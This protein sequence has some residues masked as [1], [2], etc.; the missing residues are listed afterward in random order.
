MTVQVQFDGLS[1]LSG[2]RDENRQEDQGEKYG[3]EKHH[4]PYEAEVTERLGL[5]KHQGK[6]GSDG[7]YVA[8]KQGV[9]LVGEGFALVT[10]VLEMVHIMERI[11]DR[12]ADNRGAYPEDNY[13][14]AA[15]PKGDDS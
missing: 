3:P 5:Q 12:Y 13:R 1:R 7:R 14:N 10:L 8:D 9:D 6:E 4:G 11:I 2:L 15:F